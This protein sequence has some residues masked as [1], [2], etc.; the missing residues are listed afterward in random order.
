MAENEKFNKKFLK[1]QELLIKYGELLTEMKKEEI[2]RTKNLVGDSG[3]CIVVNYYCGNSNLPNLI[4]TPPSNKNYD[5]IDERGLKY[6]I[7]TT[8]MKMTGMFHIKKTEIK[9]FDFIII[10][11]FNK[12]YQLIQIIELTWDDFLKYRQMD[13]VGKTD[14]MGRY[15]IRFSKIFL[16]ETKSKSVY[17]NE[18]INKLENEAHI[19]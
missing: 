4:L 11:R 18:N 17:Y 12:N 5:A 6:T 1:T 3:E 19:K 8:S 16:N 2:I 7:K 15:R 9:Q 13:E 10:V 14:D